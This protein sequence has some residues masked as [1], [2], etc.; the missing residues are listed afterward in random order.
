MER[1]SGLLASRRGD[2]SERGL[3][4]VDSQFRLKTL[5]EMRAAMSFPVFPY[6][7]IDRSQNTRPALALDPLS[8]KL[9]FP[10]NSSYNLL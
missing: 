1:C 5:M 7:R 6:L 10:N 4:R 3:W 8:R 2:V 9:R